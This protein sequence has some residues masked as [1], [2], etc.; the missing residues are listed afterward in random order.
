MSWTYSILLDTINDTLYDIF[1]DIL[2]IS[3][4][5]VVSETH[6]APMRYDG[7]P[8]HFNYSIIDL[9]AR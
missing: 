6:H 8:V 5:L 2:M 9:L 3:L 7:V 4:R 1:N